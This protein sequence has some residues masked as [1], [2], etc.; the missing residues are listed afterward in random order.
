MLQHLFSSLKQTVSP[1]AAGRRRMDAVIQESIKQVQARAKSQVP[2]KPDEPW[3]QSYYSFSPGSTGGWKE[4]DPTRSTSAPGGQSLKSLALYSWNIDFM[5][6]FA[7]SRMMRAVDCLAT[8]INQQH[9][10]V[11]TVI[12][13]QECVETDLVLLAAHP[14][15]RATFHLTDLDIS[16][17]QSGYY[18]TVTLIDRRLSVT[19]CFRVHY[20]QSRM[21]RDAFFV[22]IRMG[23]NNERIIRL[24]N[25]HLESLALEPPMRPPQM[26]LAAKYMRHENVHGAAAAGDFNAIQDFDRH[27]HSDNDLKDAYLELGGKE[28]SDDGY[29]WG[30]Q[31]S[32]K[33]RNQFGYSRMDKVY[34]CGGLNLKNFR[35][36]GADIFVEAEDERKHIVDLGFD[37]SW[38][39]DHLGVMARFEIADHEADTI[40]PKLA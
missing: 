20:A 31:A 8:L 24:C 29:T 39:T 2:W 18:G 17:W 34:F 40:A 26:A 28:D 25:T 11:A 30:Q 21:E 4:V 9:G 1:R 19:S 10:E 37:R 16:S 12:Y 13:L 27:L 36:F 7:D 6:P 3:H 32:T 23:Q 33:L 14:W 35:R 38:I 22:D 15:I 5:L